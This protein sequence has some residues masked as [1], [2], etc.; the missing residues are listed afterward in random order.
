MEEYKPLEFC[1]VKLQGYPTWPSYILEIN[2]NSYKVQFIG[3]RN[4]GNIKKKGMFKWNKENTQ[5]FIL[6]SKKYQE[7]FEGAVKFKE[8]VNKGIL[9]LDDYWNCYCFCHKY[10]KFSKSNVIKYISKKNINFLPLEYWDKKKNISKS[11][12]KE[13]KSEKKIVNKIKR[14]NSVK[15]K[16]K[17]KNEKYDIFQS[18]IKISKSKKIK[19]EKKEKIESK[20]IEE[21]TIKN[22]EKKNFL[23]NKRKQ[24]NDL[25]IENMNININ[26]QLNKILEAQ[27]T[28]KKETKELINLVNERYNWYKEE[29]KKKNIDFSNKNKDVSKKI[30]FLNFLHIITK[31]FQGPFN[32]NHYLNNILNFVN[33]NNLV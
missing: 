11:S 23:G 28:I 4:H 2:S 18:P 15:N 22:E 7:I 10:G 24:N 30:D 25:E 29:I 6:T 27:K 26:E 5:K 13:K 17:K 31:I 16:V 3:D 8:L 1:W 33:D 9:S 19:N 14:S 20:Y 12:N 21:K 32:V